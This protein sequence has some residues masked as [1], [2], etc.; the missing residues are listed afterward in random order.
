MADLQSPSVIPRNRS[1]AAIEEWIEEQGAILSET[2]A[3]EILKISTEAY[4]AFIETVDAT[5]VTAAGDP[6]AVDQIIPRWNIISQR[7]VQPAIQ[8]TFLAGSLFAYTNADS[9]NPIP[10]SVAQGWAA[11]VN[12]QAAEY[13][14]QAANRLRGVGE[15]LWKDI[16]RKVTQSIETGAS[17]EQLK[18]Q[19]EAL[20]QFSEYR[21]DTIGRTE[22]STAFSNGNWASDQALGE[23]GPAEKIWVAVGDAR[24][25]AAH[26]EAMSASTASPVPFNQPFS[27][28]GVEMMFPHSPGAPAGEVVNC[29]CY[30]DAL[31]PGD[32]RPDGSVVSQPQSIAAPAAPEAA[33]PDLIQSPLGS[34]EFMAD[35]WTPIDETMY[36]AVIDRFVPQT[37]GKVALTQRAEMLKTLQT[38]PRKLI[39]GDI[40][41]LDS[42][43]ISQADF[44]A[45]LQTLQQ[46]RLANRQAGRG[47]VVRF[48][49][50]IPNQLADVLADAMI[51]ATTNS[52]QQLRISARASTLSQPITTPFNRGFYQ[53]ADRTVSTRDY[54]IAHE[55]GHLVDRVNIA[56]GSSKSVSPYKKKHVFVWTDNKAAMSQYGQTD[57]LEGYAE[58]F[59]DFWT[60]AG[61]SKNS[62]TQAYAKL[63][64]WEIP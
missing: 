13:S 47:V 60:S 36:S 39:N 17:G 31:Y 2:L 58:A 38:S 22:T 28:G 11:V 15:T 24:T 34:E 59:A 27:V 3:R 49:D 8:Q 56:T 23:F 37:T 40:L 18:E 45:S 55:W 14:A 35:S 7:V 43:T 16:R 1:R 63:F 46:L 54:T 21:A 29:R 50:Q 51:A 26:L 33:I 48:Y 9:A 42:S 6:S 32:R 53:T 12:T 5:A 52:M 41:I 20:G 61:R 64:G 44:D 10:A 30:Y 62:A 57:A 25:R 19:I 4:E